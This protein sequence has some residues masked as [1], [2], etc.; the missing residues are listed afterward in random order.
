M[1]LLSD[2][3]YFTLEVSDCNFFDVYYIRTQKFWH[4]LKQ[5]SYRI[6]LLTVGEVATYVYHSS[7][8]RSSIEDRN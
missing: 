7:N 2:V 8:R 3:G 5:L 4:Q 1:A 6:S